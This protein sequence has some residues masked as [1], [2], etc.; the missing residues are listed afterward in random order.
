GVPRGPSPALLCHKHGFR[1]PGCRR[2][3][4]CTLRAGK[5]RNS[6]HSARR[7]RRRDRQEPS[8][9]LHFAARPH[10]VS[11]E[12]AAVPEQRS[13]SMIE[14]KRGVALPLLLA[15]PLLTSGPAS[16]QDLQPKALKALVKATIKTEHSNT[17]HQVAVSPDGKLIASA[18]QDKSVRLWD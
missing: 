18:S 9:P 12:T 16:G 6:C 10:K 15:M 2:W 7:R 13:F 8:K 5:K 14:V 4:D 17:I 3:R 1:K 11:D